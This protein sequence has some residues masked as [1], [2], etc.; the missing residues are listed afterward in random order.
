MKPLSRIRQALV[1]RFRRWVNRRTRPAGEVRL[2]HKRLYIF[3]SAA[4]FGFLVV[5]AMWWLLATNFENNLVFMLSF[6]L[7]AR[8]RRV[9]GIDISPKMIARAE[10]LRQRRGADTWCD[11]SF[12]VGDVSRLDGVGDGAFDVATVAMGLH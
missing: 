10:Q 7:A 4:G 12:R 2:D 6:L 9:L 3:P 5:E 8:C 1:R 11:L